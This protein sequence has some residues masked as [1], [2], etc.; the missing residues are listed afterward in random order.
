[1]IE[2]MKTHF[3][4]LGYLDFVYF[5]LLSGS[6]CAPASAPSAAATATPADALCA[7]VGESTYSG[8]RRTLRTSR[9]Q[10]NPSMI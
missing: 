6:F 1:M 8:D 2:R 7:D 5:S 9:T 10:T 4:R 3:I